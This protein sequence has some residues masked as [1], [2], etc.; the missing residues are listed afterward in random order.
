MEM[1]ITT[2]NKCYIYLIRDARDKN[3]SPIFA[4]IIIASTEMY[5]HASFNNSTVL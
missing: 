3:Q 1:G 4:R 5:E 2:K